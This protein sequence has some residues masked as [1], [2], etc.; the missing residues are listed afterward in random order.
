MKLPLKSVLLIEELNEP[1]LTSLNAKNKG[2]IW[3][4]ILKSLKGLM[5]SAERI[6][7]CSQSDCLLAYFKVSA[8]STEPFPSLKAIVC[9][10]ICI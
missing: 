1:S 9:K 6:Q 5:I 8:I 3:Y 10:R 4:I 7:F 2:S